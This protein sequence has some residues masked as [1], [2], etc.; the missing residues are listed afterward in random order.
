MAIDEAGRADGDVP[1]GCVLVRDDQL[2][3]RGHNQ[4]EK[5]QDVTDHAEIVVIRQA[6]AAQKSWRLDGTVLYTTL[7]PCPMCAEAIMQARVSRLVF[8]AYDINSGAVVSKFNLFVPGR[9]Y[10]VPTVTGGLLEEQCRTLLVEF[11]RRARK[12]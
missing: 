12:Q 1:V 5:T 11:F 2:L 9:P 4:K 3:V 10:P 6:S 7:E 8:G